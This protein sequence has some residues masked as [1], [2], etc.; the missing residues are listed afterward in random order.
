MLLSKKT[1]RQVVRNLEVFR[2]QHEE[3]R[4]ENPNRIPPAWGIPIRDMIEHTVRLNYE[5]CRRGLGDEV[6]KYLIS[7][8][9]LIEYHGDCTFPCEKGKLPTRDQIVKE[10]EKIAQ[11][12]TP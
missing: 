8:G 7:K 4:R 9:L 5:P 11:K 12:F 6:I 3:D 2:K 1:Y 10:A